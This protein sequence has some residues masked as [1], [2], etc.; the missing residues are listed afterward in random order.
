MSRHARAARGATPGRAL[1]VRAERGAALL[2]AML[3]VTLV[4]TLAAGMVWQQWKGIEVETAERARGQAAWL[5]EGAVDWARLI[6][7]T[8]AQDKER[9]NVD[10]L[11][12]P[13]NTPLKDVKLSDFL[14]ADKN[15]TVDTGLDAFLSGQIT[16]AQ[17]RFNLRNLIDDGEG[18]TEGEPPK[19]LLALRRLCEALGLPPET[20]TRIA[21]GMKG[22]DLAEDQLEDEEPVSPGAPLAPQRVNQLTWFGLEADAVRRLDPYVV[23]LP[24]STGVN[25]LTAPPEV[26]SAVLDGMDRGSAERF[27]QKRLTVDVRR[28]E[29]LQPLLPAR[30]YASMDDAEIAG[31][32]SEFFEILGELRYETFRLRELSL[33]ERRSPQDV[34][35]IR[36][37]R[38]PH[39]SQSPAPR[40]P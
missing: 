31:V 35:V 14:A 30:A 37:E 24:K 21:D 17:A 5:I 28:K 4:A 8:D 3:I 6:L 19:N 1:G 26:L 23:I 20:A 36:R 7:R 13:W 12:E 27:A 10:T 34:V 15:N 16:D 40:A 39:E 18:E 29:D 25:V 11:N 9:P 33:V 32:K 38:L 22:V 2:L